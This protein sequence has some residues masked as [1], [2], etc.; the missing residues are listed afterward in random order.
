V[1][2]HASCVYPHVSCSGEHYAQT[3]YNYNL[4]RSYLSPRWVLRFLRRRARG[5]HLSIRWLCTRARALHEEMYPGTRFCASRG[6]R[7]RFGKRN[8]IARRRKTN[9]NR[10]PLAERIPAVKL[11]H[12]K[13]A[14][15]VSQRRPGK[16]EQRFDPKY[17]RFLPY[18]RLNV[19]QARA[20]AHTACCAPFAAARRSARRL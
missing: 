17:G 7:R 13:L 18:T 4:T 16:P 10:K 5:R 12:T 6:W 1:L 3:R 20:A 19:D 11:W 2:L 9:T 14:G 8:G 15:L